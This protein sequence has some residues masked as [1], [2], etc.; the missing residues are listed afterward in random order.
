MPK[1][2]LISNPSSQ[3]NRRGL[4]G[5]HRA[6]AG[7]PDVIHVATDAG[8]DLDAA[9]IEFARQE[10]GLLVINGGDGTVQTILTRLLEDRP[11]ETVPYVAVLARGTAN[12]TA[13]DVGLRGRAAAGLARLLA[14]VRDGTIEGQIVERPILRLENIRGK[15]PQRGMM[16]GAGAVQGAIELCCRKVYARGLRGNLGIGLTLAALLFGTIFEARNHGILRGHD[17][18][19]SLDGGAENRTS[20][21]LVLATT[22]HRLIL[23]SRPFWNYEGEP[24]RYTSIAYPPDH[25]LRSAPKVLYG[26]RRRALSPKV[27]DSQGAGRIGVRL[28]EPFTVDG[29]MFEPSPDRPVLITAP[30]WVRFVRL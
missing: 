22:L 30:D 9:L 3:R 18:A 15:G 21:L 8:Q 13:A 19:V 6:V 27:Y 4:D 17:I 14:A 12:T 26:W 10:V 29:E 25:L 1:I 16:F 5:I 23:G 20:R 24:I 2:G 28:E 7:A 11:F